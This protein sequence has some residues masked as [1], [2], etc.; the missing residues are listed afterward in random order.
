MKLFKNSSLLALAL[1]LLACEKEVTSPKL[2]GYQSQLVI[3]AFISPQDT[4]LR[5]LVHQSR[6]VTDD[7]PVYASGA[8][9]DATISLSDGQR[10]IRFPPAQS[11]SILRG[12][13]YQ[14]RAEELPIKAG[15]TYYLEVRTPDG[16]LAKAQ[17]TVPV[18]NTTAEWVID[19]TEVSE[20][21]FNFKRYTGNLR[22][23]DQAGEA[24]YYRIAAEAA[25][26]QTNRRDL[27]IPLSWD[28]NYSAFFSD[29]RLDGSVFTSPT[30]TF[31]LNQLAT[32]ATLYVHLLTTDR[33]YFQYHRTLRSNE[34]GNPFVEPVLIYSN[35][36]GGLGVFAAFNRT[37]LVLKLK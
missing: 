36:E 31:S 25:I 28:G 10:T 19:S 17:C 12:Y 35:V 1:L 6:T 37:T 27:F 3:N 9:T 26:T 11:D 32:S 33:S 22:W 18:A 5:V 30:N 4:L 34:T 14:V 15:H 13:V 2:A 16:R 20:N 21:G 8:V 24:N 7:Q 29:E 23:Q